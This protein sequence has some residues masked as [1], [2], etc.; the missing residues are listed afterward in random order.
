MAAVTE[1]LAGVNELPFTVQL[2]SALATYQSKSASVRDRRNKRIAYLDFDT[3]IQ[4]ASP[5]LQAPSPQEIDEA[6]NALRKFMNVV[7][8][9]FGNTQILYE[10]SAPDGGGEALILLLKGGIRHRELCQDD[11]EWLADLQKSRHFPV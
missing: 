10:A 2:R 1:S 8:A 9:R 3:S 11:G 7:A 5:G 6:L 4:R